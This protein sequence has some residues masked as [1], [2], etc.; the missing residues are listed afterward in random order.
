M[1]SLCIS[2]PKMSIRKILQIRTMVSLY[3]MFVPEEGKNK[4][5]VNPFSWSNCNTYYAF[6]QACDTNRVPLFDR[7]STIQVILV[8]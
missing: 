2:V 5:I 4:C 8:W 1:S 7:V 3:L 6:I